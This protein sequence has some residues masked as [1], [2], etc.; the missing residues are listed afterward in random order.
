MMMVGVSMYTVLIGSGGTP[1][2]DLYG[3]WNYGDYPDT[4]DHYTT[5]A[6]PSKDYLM[7]STINAIDWGMQQYQLLHSATWHLPN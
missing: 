5:N 2:D 1:A 6:V 7:S 3:V 4:V